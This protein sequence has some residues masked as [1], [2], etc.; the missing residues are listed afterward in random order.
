MY[1]FWFEPDGVVSFNQDVTLLYQ[2][3]ATDFT[4][5]AG[6]FYSVAGFGEHYIQLDDGNDLL[7]LEYEAPG[8]YK[9][10][11]GDQPFSAFPGAVKTAE[12]K[13]VAST[14]AL[15]VDGE[16]KEIDHYNVNG[17]NYFKLRDLACVLGGTADAFGVDYD[18]PS[19]TVSLTPG[20]AYAPIEGDLAIGEDKSDTAV[21]SNQKITLN[22]DKL[23]LVAVNIGGCNY[24]KLADL[25]PVLGFELSYDQG[26]R[27]AQIATK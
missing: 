20:A 16:A 10:Y 24:F 8:N 26:E 1:G 18:K 23:S 25:A 7:L 2:G 6:E 15:T 4:L 22:G 21:V 19:R 17:Y 9:S 11:P 12:L 3:A 13:C 27:T 5:K 14:Q